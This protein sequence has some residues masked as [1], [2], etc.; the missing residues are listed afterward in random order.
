MS[1]S[2]LRTLCLSLLLL[3]PLNISA[4]DQLSPA[5]GKPLQDAQKRIQAKQ[6]KDALPLIEQA[7]AQA[8]TDYEK[9]VIAQMTGSAKAGAG[10]ALGA[11]QAFEQVL[12]AQRLPPD[13]QL[14]I[15]EAVAGTYVRAKQYPKALEWL[16]KYQAGGGTKPDIL[17][18]RPQIHYLNGDYAKAAQLA[19]AQIGAMEKAGGKPS[20]DSLKLLASSL[21]KQKDLTGYRQ[22]LEKLVQYYPTPAYWGDV[23]QRTATQPGFNRGLDLDLYRLLRATGNLDS[24]KDV[25]EMAQLAIQAGL[26]GEAKAI[27]DEGYANKILGQGAQSDID[28]QTRLKTLVEKK[29]ADDQK[30]I[31]ATDAQV[32]AAPS[33]DPLVKTGLAYVTYGNPQKGLPMM[34]QG[35]QKGGLKNA[36]QS[37]LH[38]GYAYLAAGDKAKATAALKTVQGTDGSATFARLWTLIAQQPQASTAAPAHIAAARPAS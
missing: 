27:L 34:E 12:A 37:K 22:A 17:G 11:A 6:Y 2:A 5:V 31:A 20:Q 25:M 33:G 18:L 28:R 23:I 19:A 10:D 3:L 4:K 16:E 35:I 29:Y 8:K 36:D 26:P 38:L 14:K 24:A 32:A 7:R 30:A 15:T 9:F 13:E 21:D 1:N